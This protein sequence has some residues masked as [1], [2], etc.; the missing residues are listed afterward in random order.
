MLSDMDVQAAEGAI[1]GIVVAVLLAIFTLKIALG[2][3]LDR[4]RPAPPREPLVLGKRLVLVSDTHGQ[5]RSL[6]SL[7]SIIHGRLDLAHR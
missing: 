2:L 3:G 5:H 4:S 1:I 7:Q 6:V